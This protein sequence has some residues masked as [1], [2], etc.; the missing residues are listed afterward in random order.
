LRR[1]CKRGQ[2]GGAPDVARP[3]RTVRLS[4]GF[5]RSLPM[6]TTVPSERPRQSARNDRTFQLERC[7]DKGGARAEVDGPN[8]VVLEA[9]DVIDLLRSEIERAGGP[10]AYSKKVEVDRATIHRTLKR[11]E[12]PGRAIIS[13]LDLCVVYSSNDPRMKLVLRAEKG[14]NIK[15]VR[16]ATGPEGGRK[17]LLLL[18]DGR[19]VEAPTAQIAL[20]ACLYN[21]LGSVVPYRRLCSAIGHRSS[22]KMHLLREHM[23]LVRRILAAHKLPYVLAVSQ[24]VGYALCEVA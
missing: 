5:V 4:L 1:A 6:S 7:S 2:S 19:S 10:T 22:R 11:Q 24:N 23:R 21:E 18:V 3:K 9:E 8:M 16:P 15:I 13:A 20:L 14:S 17:K 12:R